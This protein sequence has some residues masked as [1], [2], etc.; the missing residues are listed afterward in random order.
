MQYIS[1]NGV[2]VHRET[3]GL[4]KVCLLEQSPHVQLI[5]GVCKNLTHHLVGLLPADQ[6]QTFRLPAD[7]LPG[8]DAPVPYEPYLT[9]HPELPLSVHE[10]QEEILE[11]D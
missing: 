2:N 1:Q 9:T 7:L 10:V 6:F 8:K 5:H 3:S 11:E 4:L